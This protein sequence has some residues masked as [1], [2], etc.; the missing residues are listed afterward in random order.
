MKAI[1]LLLYPFALIYGTGVWLRNLMFD[2]G[3]IGTKSFPIAVINVGNLV[4]GGTGKSPHV[5]YLVKLISEKY[6]VATLSRGYGRKTSGFKEVAGDST[7]FEVGD[8]PRM[9]R[10]KFGSDVTVNVDAN[11]KRGIAQIMSKNAELQCIIMDDAYQHRYVTPGMNI[12]LT[13]YARLYIN[14]FLLPTG[15]LREPASG[16]KRADVIVVTKCPP[17]FSPVDARAIRKSLKVKPYQKVFFSYLKSGKLKPVYQNTEVAL[18]EKLT[19]KMSVVLVT[20]IAKPANMLFETKEKVNEVVHLKFPDHH[21]FTMSDI[22]KMVQSYQKLKSE[23]KIILTTEKDAMRLHVDG[24]KEQ[25]KDIPLFYIPVE[26][27]FH[28]KDIEDFNETIITYVERNIT[29]N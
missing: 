29:S 23:N 17:I 22:N 26:V 9:F 25:L 19:S 24:I 11:R 20:G 10:H 7:F 5:E 14:D 15:Y 28:G 4:A 6:K 12:L 18:T 21:V 13:D 8:E 1:R 3:I 2:L 27:A 16:S